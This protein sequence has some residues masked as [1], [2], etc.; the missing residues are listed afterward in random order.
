MLRVFALL[1]SAVSRESTHDLWLWKDPEKPTGKFAVLGFRRW[2][3]VAPVPFIL[4]IAGYSII[5]WF[6]FVVAATLMARDLAQASLIGIVVG[7]VFELA[8]LV[9]AAFV[10]LLGLGA[11][12]LF[13]LLYRT[14]GAVAPGVLRTYLD[15]SAPPWAG[16]GAN[17][18]LIRLAVPPQITTLRVAEGAPLSSFVSQAE[19]ATFAGLEGVI[20]GPWPTP[21]PA[22]P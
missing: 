9:L 10:W 2:L 19:E 1:G 13:R 21:D 14:A 4:G 8:A 11:F 20:G 7:G 16:W 12:L 6:G 5:F 3:A 22:G 15:T 17:E 18:H